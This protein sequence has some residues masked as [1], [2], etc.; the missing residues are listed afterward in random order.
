MPGL[1]TSP[2]LIGLCPHVPAF[3]PGYHRNFRPCEASRRESLWISCELPI[4]V[5]PRCSLDLSLFPS[6]ELLLSPDSGPSGEMIVGSRDLSL[7]GMFVGGR[8]EVPRHRMARYKRSSYR[9]ARRVCMAFGRSSREWGDGGCG[10][11]KE[12]WGRIVDVQYWRYC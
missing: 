4:P 7:R 1:L 3:S 5:R 8:G 10:W 12:V 11:G 2:S 9:G 6:F